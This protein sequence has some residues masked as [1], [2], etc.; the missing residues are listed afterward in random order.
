[1]ANFNELQ[2]AINADGDIRLIELCSGTIVFTQHIAFYPKGEMTFTCPNGDC[3][4]DADS[5][6][7]LFH[8]QGGAGKVSFD[9][10]TFKD[11]NGIV[12]PE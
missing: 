11:G 12:S 7:R 5:K 6:T 4:L 1:M 9:G 2:A 10:I 8:I 3:V